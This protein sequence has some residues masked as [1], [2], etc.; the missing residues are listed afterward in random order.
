MSNKVIV[1][2]NWDCGRQGNVESTFVCD[3]GKL[4]ASFGKEV[5]FGEILGKHSEIYG[6]LDREDITIKSD[7][8]EFI[9]KF[10]EIMGV[11]WYSG[12]NPIIAIDEQE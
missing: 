8:Q 12:H 1:E 11:G 5:Y 6:T 3:A 7:D 10:E 2:F 9:D 4:E